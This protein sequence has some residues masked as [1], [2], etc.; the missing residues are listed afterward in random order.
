MTS[1]HKQKSFVQR[2]EERRHN[3]ITIALDTWP[4]RVLRAEASRR[5]WQLLTVWYSGGRVPDG[6]ACQGALVSEL[7]DS[8][9]V[10]TLQQSVGKIVRLGNFPHPMDDQVPAI[11]P[12]YPLYGRRAA[13]HFYERQFKHVAFIGREPWSDMQ[14]L[15]EGFRQRAEALDMQCH[16]LRFPRDN[17]QNQ[18]RHEKYE[19]RQTIFGE[20]LKKI[21]RPMGLLA[22]NN[23]AA[24]EMCFFIAQAG[25]DVPTDVAVIG[26]GDNEDLCASAHPPVSSFADGRARQVKAAC[27]LLASWMDGEPPPQ[28]P[29][30]VPPSPIVERQSTNVLA[31]ENQI[32]ARALRFV[33]DHFAEPLTISDVAEAVAVSRS[34]LDHLFKKHF[35]RT[36]KAELSRKRLNKARDL[37]RETEDSI[38]RVA[39]AS[40]FGSP[41]YMCEVFNREFGL[42]P[43]QFRQERKGG[44]ESSGITFHISGPR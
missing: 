2:L 20:W 22:S 43:S 39:A 14:P 12:D 36:V 10:K 16:L 30:L 40:G 6:I 17:P 27:D 44:D 24:A 3:Q 21:P 11:L 13:E 42:S 34:K 1:E 7:P 26:P 29:V 28:E 9:F 25:F 8:D 38:A 19:S 23:Y 41:E 37:L 31:V 35:H 15:Y 5:G 32:V 4:D 18:S 33:W